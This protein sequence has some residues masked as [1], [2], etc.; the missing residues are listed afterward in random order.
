MIIKTITKHILLVLTCVS[1]VTN[2]ETHQKSREVILDNDQVSVVRLVYP[3]E[4]ESGMHT[5]VHANRTVY[6]IAGGTLALVAKDKPAKTQII[7]AQTGTILYLPANTHNV[8]NV[9][10]TTIILLEHELK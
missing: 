1:F 5:H 6:F 4:T 9:G 8:R 10:T 3:P 2:A 7:E